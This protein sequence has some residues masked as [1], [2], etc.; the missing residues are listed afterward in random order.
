MYTFQTYMNAGRVQDALN[1]IHTTRRIGLPFFISGHGLYDPKYS[2]K[3]HR[4]LH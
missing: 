4:F 1:V 2:V 3:Y